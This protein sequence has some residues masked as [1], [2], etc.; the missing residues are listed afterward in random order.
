MEAITMNTTPDPRYAAPAR[1]LLLDVVREHIR[2][3]H[4][5]LRTEK[6]YV[7]WI[8]FYVRFHNRHHPRDLECGTSRM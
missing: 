8:R 6:S 5:S 2:T 7:H 1:P 3:R 4:L